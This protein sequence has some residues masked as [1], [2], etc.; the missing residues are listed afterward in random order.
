MIYKRNIYKFAAVGVFL[1]GI[2]TVVVGYTERSANIQT[3]KSPTSFRVVYHQYMEDADGKHNIQAITE[4][5]QQSNG[6]WKEIVSY[7]NPK[8][9]S[10]DK[11]VEKFALNGRGLFKVD[12][13]NKKLVFLG[14]RPETPNVPSSTDFKNSPDFVREDSLL[15]YQTFVLRHKIDDSNYTESFIAPSLQGVP[16]KIV[17]A[18]EKN[19]TVIEAVS[20]ES[21]EDS[22]SLIASMPD[23]PVDYGSFEKS[24]NA[25]EKIGNTEISERMKQELD[26]RKNSESK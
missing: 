8:D 13:Q 18:A 12:E 17:F 23:Y 20:I 5:V 15:N 9:G 16:L 4:R 24:I 3:A 26:K 11:R 6:E 1:L 19:R 21:V 2:I 14:L 25:M 10:V 22:P 7:L